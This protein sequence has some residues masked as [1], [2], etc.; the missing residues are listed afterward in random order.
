M[1]LKLL[2]NRVLRYGVVGGTA[3]AVHL[4]VLLLLGQWISLSLANPIAFLAASIAGYL[5]HALLTFREETGGKQFARRWLL[6]QYVV[7]I[8]VCALLP[9]LKAPTLVLVFTP[10]VLNA[11]I[12][13]Q[14]ARFSLRRRVDT[15][16]PLRHADDLGL[17]PATNEAILR[18]A[19]SGQLDG[20]SVL[21][22]GPVAAEGVTAWTALVAAQPHLQLVLHLCLTEGPCCAPP[23]LVPDLVNAKGHLR[24]SF[25]QWLL[26]SLWPPRHP[27]RR[28]LERQLGLEVEAQI[29]QFRRLCGNGPIHLDGHQHIHLVPVVLDAVL[30]RATTQQI[31]WLRRTDEPLPTGLPISDWWRA[32]RDAGLLKWV[33]LQ[34]LSRRAHP[35][36]RRHGIVSNQSFA[37]VLFTGHMAGAP[38]RAAW[39][40]LRSTSNDGSGTPPLLLT[41]PAAPLNTDL[42]QAG[43]AVSAPFAASPWR[44]RE[45][46]ALQA[47]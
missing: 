6:L 12:W 46:Q 5:G 47:L 27:S 16:I 29:R 42:A 25:G 39:S 4:G 33:V 31:T 2:L 41:H 1:R 22:N 17:S 32:I 23:E 35:A 3:A 10:T 38:L 11:L 21:V 36:M 8:S 24:R 45:W 18:L 9:L 26:L 43:F 20:T 37:G 14:A 34:W 40:T 44:Q 15:V 28:R 7:N 13:S 30:K 19:A